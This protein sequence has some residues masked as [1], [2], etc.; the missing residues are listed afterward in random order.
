[1]EIR[2][3]G[4]GFHKPS[5]ATGRGLGQDFKLPEVAAAEEEG[6]GRLGG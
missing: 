1:M 5:R 4:I 2:K 6:W 3:P